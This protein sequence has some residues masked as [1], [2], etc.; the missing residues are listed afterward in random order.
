L[1]ILKEPSFPVWRVRIRLYP[2]MSE[3]FPS[4]LAGYRVVV[5]RIN[6]SYALHDS[7]IEQYSIKNVDPTLKNTEP[8]ESYTLEYMI[9]RRPA[10]LMEESLDLSY[11]VY[12]E[13]EA[14]GL[15]KSCTKLQ[16]VVRGE[17]GKASSTTL[18][19]APWESKVDTFPAM[20]RVLE[21]KAGWL[22]NNLWSAQE[23]PEGM[24]GTT[25][26]VEV[27]IDNHGGNGGGYSMLW[28]DLV[29]DD[30]ITKTLY[31][32][33]YDE[34]TPHAQAD[35]FS[36]VLCRRGENTTQPTQLCP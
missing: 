27:V 15:Q 3:K 6:L 35:I 33:Y 18:S 12:L 2:G 29:S 34:A 26:W 11:Y 14:C 16:E 9:L 25:P 10:L 23:I 30:S 22:E 4:Q 13:N 1:R 7:L 24:N 21:V 20:L 31:S 5:D 17:W 28:Q 32:I 36:A 19:K 8:S